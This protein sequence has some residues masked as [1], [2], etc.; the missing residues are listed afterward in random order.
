[1]R[2]SRTRRTQLTFCIPVYNIN[3]LG[4]HRLFFRT[5]RYIANIYYYYHLPSSS[6]SNVCKIIDLSSWARGLEKPHFWAP[7]SR[8][9]SHTPAVDEGYCNTTISLYS[10]CII[11]IDL[12]TSI[13]IY[14]LYYKRSVPGGRDNW[15]RIDRSAAASNCFPKY[16]FVRT[17]EELRRNSS[18][19]DVGCFGT[20]RKKVNPDLQPSYTA[21]VVR[22]VTHDET[23]SS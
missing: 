10:L 7:D 13:S 12:C 9:P 19:T 16:C 21:F 2:S 20:S 8:E 5:C 1:L 22:L 23:F 4:T 6:T 14:T 11:S 18:L 17:V 3:R 15:W